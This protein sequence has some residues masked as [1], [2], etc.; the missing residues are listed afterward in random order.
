MLSGGCRLPFSG[1]AAIILPHPPNFYKAAQ[2]K[3][4]M[5]SGVPPFFVLAFFLGCAIIIVNEGTADRRRAP[6]E[7]FG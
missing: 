4:G 3:R 7:I 2:A 1:S 5:P 6:L